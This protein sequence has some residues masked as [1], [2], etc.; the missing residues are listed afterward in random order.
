LFE[1]FKFVVVVESLELW[2]GWH[3][4][5]IDGRVLNG[6]EREELVVVLEAKRFGMV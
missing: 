1:L 6:S 5:S 2:H 4:V 3:L